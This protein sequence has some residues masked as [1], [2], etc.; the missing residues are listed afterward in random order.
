MSRSVT[1]RLLPAG[2]VLALVLVGLLA[3][4]GP[5]VPG[6]VQMTEQERD[7][8]EIRLVENRID[9]NE[10]FMDHQRSPLP[11]DEIPVFQGLNYYFPAPEFRWRVKFEPEARPDTVMLTKAK[12][13]KVPY[14]K[15][16]KGRFKHQGKVYTLWVFGPADTTAHGDYLWLP[17]YDKTNGRQTYAGGRYLDLTVDADGMVDLDF[18]FAYNPL[19]DYNH[20]RYD[21]TLPPEENRLP[22]EVLAGEKEF[23]PDE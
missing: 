9:K 7:A 10:Q 23:R 14:V 13:R 2:A 12:G 18:N 19:C 16:G 5:D 11:P 15:R 17:F 1:A 8:W 22:F 6:P 21:C 20:A 4:C 3:G